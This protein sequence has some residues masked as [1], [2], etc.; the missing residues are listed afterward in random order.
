MC[1]HAEKRIKRRD[2]DREADRLL[3]LVEVAIGLRRQIKE[4]GHVLMVGR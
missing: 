1:G 2:V 4:G 3:G